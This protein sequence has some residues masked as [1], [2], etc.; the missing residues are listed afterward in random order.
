MGVFW[1]FLSNAARYLFG[2]VFRY[3]PIRWLVL[4][5]VGFLLSSFIEDLFLLMPSYL[6]ASAI[7]DAADSAFLP[8]M[9]YFLEYFKIF[10][11]GVSTI[12][13]AYAIRFFI[14]RM[15]VVG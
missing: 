6:S 1:S 12:F 4:I 14:K 8:G 5:A 11:Y 13:S 3:A 10:P 2:L 9:W 15:P 7:D